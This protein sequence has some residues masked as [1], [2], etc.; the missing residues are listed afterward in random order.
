MAR[1]DRSID[2]S[3]IGERRGQHGRGAVRAARRDPH[4]ASLVITHAGLGN[5]MAAL[6]RGVPLLCTP[7]GRDQ[8]FNAGQVQAGE[9][10]AA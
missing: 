10:F 2:R 4:L 5:T 6:G 9:S 8:F 3:R 1:D 7:M